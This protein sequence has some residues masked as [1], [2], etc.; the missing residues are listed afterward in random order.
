MAAGRLLFS[1]PAMAGGSE[2]NGLFLIGKYIEVPRP[3][4]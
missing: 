4:L 1:V 3:K 2:C